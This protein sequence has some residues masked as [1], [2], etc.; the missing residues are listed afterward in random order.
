MGTKPWKGNLN[1]GSFRPWTGR[2]ARRKSVRALMV[3]VK[4]HSHSVRMQHGSCWTS[5][6][7][8]QG[9]R[10]FTCTH[11]CSSSLQDWG[12]H[13]DARMQGARRIR[14]LMHACHT[15]CTAQKVQTS[16]CPPPPSCTPQA[17]ASEQRHADAE[18]L[19]MHSVTAWPDHPKFSLALAQCIFL[20][21]GSPERALPWW[22]GRRAQDGV[23]LGYGGYGGRVVGGGRVTCACGAFLLCEQGSSSGH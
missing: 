8:V 9:R 14:A 23:G 1:A 10:A 16:A 18:Q 15:R 20:D 21:R 22:V 3:M 11:A 19:L 5:M 2:A 13:A 4:P 7:Q 17:A 12:M 6:R